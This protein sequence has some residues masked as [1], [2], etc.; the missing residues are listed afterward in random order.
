MFKDLQIT[1]YDFFGY[2]LPGAISLVAS[3]IV[4]H[5]LFERYEPLVLWRDI[6][7]EALGLLSLIAYLL[8]HLGQAVGNLLQVLPFINPER[9]VSLC[10]QL[11]HSL[12]T[13]VSSRFGIDADRF[14]IHQLY[15]LCDESLVHHGSVAEREIYTYREGFYRGTMVALLFLSLASTLLLTT[16]PAEI[17]VGQAHI[18]ATRP[19]LLLLAASFVLSA[20]LA[21]MRYKRFARYRVTRCLLRFL[22]FATSSSTERGQDEPT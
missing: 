14:T 13:A 1:L 10:S 3:W 21:L 8:G 19:R 4:I 12:R 11:D 15:E 17:Q 9:S 16:T 2:F 22:A 20:L 5:L 7:P 18:E 6:S